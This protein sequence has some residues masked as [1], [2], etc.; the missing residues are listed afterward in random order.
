MGAPLHG[1]FHAEVLRGRGAGSAAQLGTWSPCPYPH[2]F[3][4]RTH[5]QG[6]V[7][8]R[9]VVV[10]RG[11]GERGSVDMAP[12]GSPLEGKGPGGSPLEGKG[13]AGSHLGGRSWGPGGTLAGHTEK[14][15]RGLVGKGLQGREAWRA[16]VPQDIQGWGEDSCPQTPRNSFHG[17]WPQILW[18]PPRGERERSQPRSDK[19]P[20]AAT[21][22]PPHLLQGT[23]TQRGAFMTFAPRATGNP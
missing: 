18:S 13:P 6:P 12:E 10:H 7:P 15:E 2:S 3:T 16:G 17:A 11:W 1:S 5:S 8:G 23:R 4:P 9:P 22:A 20:E 21:A 14:A 19:S